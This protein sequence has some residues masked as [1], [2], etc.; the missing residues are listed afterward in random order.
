[1]LETNGPKNITNFFDNNFFCTL[2]G[3]TNFLIERVYI[4]IFVLCGGTYS[5]LC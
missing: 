1:M 3:K 4:E 5:K 2:L